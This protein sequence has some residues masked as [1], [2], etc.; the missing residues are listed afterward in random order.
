MTKFVSKD[1][2]QTFIADVL[3]ALGVDEWQVE[4]VS[5]SLVSAS[6]RGVDSHGIRL[7]TPYVASIKGGRTNAQATITHRKTFPSMCVV[8]ADHAV[9]AAAGYYAIDRCMEIAKELGMAMAMV[10]NSTHPGCMACMPLRAA[11]Q[12][13]MAMAFTNTGPKLQ[14]FGGKGSFFGTNPVAFAAP[15]V[16]E[17]PLCLD[18][19]TSTIP[20]NKVEQARAGSGSTLPPGTC[21]D[22]DGQETTNPDLV[23]TL[24]PVGGYKGHGLAAMVEVMCC[25]ATGMAFG[26]NTVQMYGPHVDQTQKRC[27]GQCYLVMRCDGAVSEEEFRKSLQEMTEDVRKEPPMAG[28]SSV[29]MPGDPEIATACHRRKH[30]IP[31]NSVEWADFTRFAKELNLDLPTVLNTSSE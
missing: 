11:K 3:R 9:G 4:T 16:E 18:M 29:M 17:D 25:S 26:H 21:A 22:A 15:R 12:G 31:L 30:G 14:A 24:V 28:V 7:L 19:A 13:F 2:L 8:D 6:L 27:I 1:L 20:W 5:D 23:R 10:Q